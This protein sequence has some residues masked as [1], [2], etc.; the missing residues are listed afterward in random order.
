[1]KSTQEKDLALLDPNRRGLG[2]IRPT[3]E[4]IGDITQTRHIGILATQGTINSES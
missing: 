1:M 4:C 2:V 3:A